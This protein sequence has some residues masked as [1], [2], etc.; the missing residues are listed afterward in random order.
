MRIINKEKE[1]HSRKEYRLKNYD[2]SNPGSYFFTVCTKERKNYFWKRVGASI[3]RPS[4]I[5]LSDYGKHVDEAI[6]NIPKIYSSVTVDCYVIMPDHIHILLTVHSD[7]NGRPMDAPTTERIFKQF[8]GY[9]T[10]RVGFSIWQKLY[11]DHVIR[12]QQDY[13]EHVLYIQDNPRR[14]IEKM[15]RKEEQNEREVDKSI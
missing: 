6:K 11:Y 2:Y 1:Y 3:G 14:W 12:N 15:S 7:S 9:I 8:K 5:V 13:F 4:D 10:R